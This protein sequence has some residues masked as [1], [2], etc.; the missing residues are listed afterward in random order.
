MENV[1]ALTIA[2]VFIG[3]L[4]VIYNTE[5]DNYCNCSGMATKYHK[6]P[7]GGFEG[8]AQKYRTNFGWP[9]GTPYDSFARQMSR[10]QMNKQCAPNAMAANQMACQPNQFQSTYNPYASTSRCQQLTRNMGQKIQQVRQQ[11]QQ[12]LNIDNVITQPKRVSLFG[13]PRRKLMT[14]GQYSNPQKKNGCVPDYGSMAFIGGYGSSGQ[15]RNNQPLLSQDTQTFKSPECAYQNTYTASRGPGRF[16]YGS[17]SGNIA[18]Y[19]QAPS[20]CGLPML[21]DGSP[22][23]LGPAGSFTAPPPQTGGCDEAHGYNLAIGVL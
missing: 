6:A 2:A 22:S 19:G 9:V 4:A 23:C 8:G 21:S 12:P 20:G 14:S 15:L 13:K 18:A 17:L 3:I 1:I 10:P 16:G 11:Q 7:G 5:K